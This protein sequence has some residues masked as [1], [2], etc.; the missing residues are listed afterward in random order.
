MCLDSFFQLLVYLL[1]FSFYKTCFLLIKK[2]KNH[3]VVLVLE[4]LFYFSNIRFFYPS[5]DSLWTWSEPGF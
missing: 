1:E 3:L 2:K 5:A 4:F